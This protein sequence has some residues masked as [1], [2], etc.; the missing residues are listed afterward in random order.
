[1]GTNNYLYIYYFYFI[2]LT[3]LIHFRIKLI[4][5]V[6][7]ILGNQEIQYKSTLLFAF[8]VTKNLLKALIYFPLL[9]EQ[10]YPKNSCRLNMR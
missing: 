3:I 4:R 6:C 5:K 10:L 1:M 9:Y 2:L 8:D 7:K